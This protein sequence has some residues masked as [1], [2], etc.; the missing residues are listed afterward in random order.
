MISTFGQVLRSLRRFY[1]S[2]RD[3]IGRRVQADGSGPNEPWRTVVG[4]VRDLKERGYVENSKVGVYLPVK[5]DTGWVPEHLAVRFKG[6]AAR[7]VQPVTAA[8]HEVDAELSVSLVQ[9]M[10]AIVDEDLSERRQHQTLSVAFAGVAIALAALGIFAVLSFNVLLRTRELGVRIA[11][12]AQ[13]AEIAGLVVRNGVVMTGLGIL[14]GCASAVAAERLLRSLL[15]RVP[16]SS[17]WLFAGVAAFFL[18]VSAAASWWPAVR[19]MRIDPMR[20]LREE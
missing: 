3:A 7:I 18:A 2:A 13:P 4:V 20:V 1:P 6:D 16:E 11:V 8:I 19:A 5:Q 9:T 12:G 17:P 10:D 14:L 15:D